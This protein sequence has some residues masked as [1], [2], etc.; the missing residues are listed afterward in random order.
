MSASVLPASGRASIGGKAQV[1]APSIG[2][3]PSLCLM[4]TAGIASRWEHPAAL[5]LGA[6]VVGLLATAAVVWV[7]YLRFAYRAPALHVSLETANA[8][9]AVLVAYLVY[10]RF[11][12]SRRLQELLLV[13]A[14]CTVAVANL[15]LTALPS[16]VTIGRDEEYSRWAALTI[17]LIGTVVLTW[18][19]LT[20]PRVRVHGRQAAV[21]VG[22]V[23][24]V[25]LVVSLAGLAYGGKLPPTVDP[26]LALGDATRPRLVAHPGVLGV[27]AL[28]AALYGI[29][30]VAL[31]RQAA[32]S[33]D[34]LLRWVGAGCVLAAFARVHYL[35]FPS[36]YSDFVYTGDLLRL[37]F[38]LLMLVGAAREIRSYWEARTW[39]AVLEDRRRVAR[40]LHDGVIQELG[41]IRSESHGIPARLPAKN[42]IIEACDRA[43]DEARVAVQTLGH[44]RD[45]PL[46]V[47][48]ARGAVEMADRYRTDIQT[49]LDPAVEANPD[50][51]HALVRITREA[52]ANAVRHGKA[53]RVWVQLAGTGEKRRLVIGDDGQGFVVAAVAAGNAGYGLIS[54]RERAR[55]LPG[56]LDIETEPGR[57][58]EVTVTW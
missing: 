31:T 3:R 35:L 15:A 6:L 28:G 51:A 52:V 18:A 29:A 58:S 48:L 54:M 2:R 23:A 17:R 37:G 21:G 1:D 45:E 40:E 22:A 47:M 49:D 32:R 44:E 4:A 50:Q 42:N 5:A 41:Y 26:S 14:L 7:P 43:L 53:E 55:A 46:S 38:Y 16:A 36:L 34:Q 30:A 57:G 33:T 11:R 20:A 39:A 12:E 8:V 25:V 27:Q 56:S 10:G 13:L 24:A 9:I 19:A